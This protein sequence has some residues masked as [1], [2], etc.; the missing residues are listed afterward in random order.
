MKERARLTNRAAFATTDGSLGPCPEDGDCRTFAPV[1]V[2]ESTPIFDAFPPVRETATR[3]RADGSLESYV[4]HAISFD[5][6]G[7][8]CHDDDLCVFYATIGSAA[9]SVAELTPDDGIE[10]RRPC[11]SSCRAARWPK[12][13]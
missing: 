1:I 6:P 10:A 5:E 9:L 12:A 13:R 3:V 8:L 11:R 7:A 4:R 2:D